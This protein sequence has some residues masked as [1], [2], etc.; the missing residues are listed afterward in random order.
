[1]STYENAQ[2]KKV[3]TRTIATEEVDAL[4]DKNIDDVLEYI[5]KCNLC[6]VRCN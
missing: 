5:D 4:V 1:M 3:L 2:E 6:A